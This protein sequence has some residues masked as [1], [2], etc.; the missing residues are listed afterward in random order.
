MPEGDVFLVGSQ[1]VG[2]DVTMQAIG[3]TVLSELQ[4][5]N[6]IAETIQ[7]L[8][9][10]G[11]DVDVMDFAREM[12]VNGLVLAVDSHPLPI[13][14]EA[15]QE[16]FWSS[17]IPPERIKPF[18][19]R[20]AWF[21][22]GLLFLFCATLFLVR[23]DRWPTF[24]DFFFHPDPLVCFVGLVPIHL[25]F[26]VGH[27]IAHFPHR[28]VRRPDYYRRLH[29]PLPPDLPTP[30]QQVPSSS[31][32]GERRT[33]ICYKPRSAGVPMVLLALHHRVGRRHLRYDLLLRQAP[34][35]SASFWRTL[36]LALIF[37]PPAVI[38]IIILVRHPLK[39]E[40]IA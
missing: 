3:V 14:P 11:H 15:R 1:E 9:L 8:A 18:F 7:V 26:T 24:E 34:I 35:G 10:R 22:Y 27:E 36:G 16:P 39:Q 12:V 17:A 2:C 25:L 4:Q 6:T 32:G 38:P 5:G 40:V 31:C 29:K 19:S 20:M 37:A 33:R 23:P 30:D 13:H 28:P 21:I